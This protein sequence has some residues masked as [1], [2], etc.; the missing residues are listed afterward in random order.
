MD[1]NAAQD[2]HARLRA[3]QSITDA[4]RGAHVILR[5]PAYA[6]VPAAALPWIADHGKHLGGIV[7]HS[8]HPVTVSAWVDAQRQANSAPSTVAHM[9]APDYYAD[10]PGRC[11]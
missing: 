11:L 6:P 1:L 3:V 10:R 4:P 7:V 9:P 2:D 8:P 5:V